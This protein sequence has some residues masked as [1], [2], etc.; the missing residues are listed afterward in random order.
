MGF[1][2]FNSSRVK[3]VIDCKPNK[4][5]IR[6]AISKVYNSNFKKELNT[7]VNPY[8]E[9]KSSELILDIL[10]NNTLPRVPKKLFLAKRGT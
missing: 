4:D 6:K 2:F 3:S 5:S 7:V 10:I 9:G 8:G 1:D